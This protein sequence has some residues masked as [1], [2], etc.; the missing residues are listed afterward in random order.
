[1]QTYSTQALTELKEISPIASCSNSTNSNSSSRKSLSALSAL[2]STDRVTYGIAE[3]LEIRPNHHP[4]HHANPRPQHAEASIFD[5]LHKSTTRRLGEAPVYD[6]PPPR[7]QPAVV[8]S[9]KTQA[10]IPK[11][12]FG[13]GRKST[14][15]AV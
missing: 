11:R 12:R 4:I 3:I 5:S 9:V 15:I 1:M 14:A 7:P 2:P 8:D 10:V 13:F 6:S